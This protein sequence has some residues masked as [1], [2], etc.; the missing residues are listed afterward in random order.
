MPW[1]NSRSKRGSAWRSSRRGS[2]NG[3]RNVGL[4]PAPERMFPH[5]NYFEGG[6]GGRCVRRWPDHQVASSTSS[7]R[8]EERP[9]MSATISPVEG[10]RIVVNSLQVR[11]IANAAI[12]KFG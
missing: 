10:D 4:S 11:A 9:D 12:G 7:T 2:S 8:L 1:V 6:A 5:Y 3:G